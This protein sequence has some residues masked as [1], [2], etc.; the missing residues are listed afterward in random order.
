MIFLE[1][2]SL[3]FISKQS[4]KTFAKFL[5]SVGV[6]SDDAIFKCMETAIV[7][8]TLYFVKEIDLGLIQNY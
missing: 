5:K 8:Y 1:I 2:T 7:L 4:Y 3:G 6:N